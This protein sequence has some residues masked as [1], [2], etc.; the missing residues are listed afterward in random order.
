MKKTPFVGLIIA[1]ILALVLDQPLSAG[2]KQEA[3][4]SRDSLVV[5]VGGG[6]TGGDYEP[7]GWEYGYEGMSMFHTALLKINTRVETEPDLATG[8]TISDDGLVYT[9]TLRSDVRFSDGTPLR[10]EDVVFTYETAKN[11]GGSV[12][13]TMMRS[14]E[15][16]DGNTVRFTL[17]KVFSPFIRTTALVGIV[18]KNGYGPNYSRNP[19]GTGP[20]KLKQIDANQQLIVE[21]N[22]Y[23]YGTK[24]PF[25]Q[26]TFLNIDEQ[27]ALAAARSGQIDVVMVNPEYARETVRGMHLETIRTSDH[28][29][30]NLPVIRRTTNAA[31]QIVGSDVTGDGAVRKALNIGISRREIIDNALNGI[32]SPS[33]VRFEGLPW[34]SEEPGLTDNQVA[35]AQ[36]ILQEAGWVD[37]D[38]DGI[39]EKNGTPCEFRITGR[40]DDLQRYNLAVALSQN[41]RKLGINI[42]AESVDWPTAQKQARAIPT[43]IGTGSYSFYDVFNAFHSSLGGIDTVGLGN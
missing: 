24:S 2:A 37:S 11:A 1:S 10:A 41:A 7:W 31:G 5:S 26:I 14:A 4:G 12:D 43:C 39:R 40:A 42:I 36:R 16:I 27:T 8:F 29:G 32:G 3:P 17:N 6:I 15:V 22:P 21:P 35:E 9:Y 38:G 19:V 28:R 13:L 25:T 33:W 23:Y 30:F 18:P 34:A 20:F